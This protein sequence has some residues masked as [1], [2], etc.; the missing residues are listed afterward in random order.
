MG[1][2]REALEALGHPDGAFPEPRLLAELFVRFQAQVPLRDAPEGSPDEHLAAWLGDGA[3]LCGAARTAAFAALAAAAGFALAPASAT[4]ASGGS[5]AVL[6]AG[7]GRLLLDPSFPLPAPLPFDPPAES[8]ACGYGA[9][10][11]RDEAGGHAVALETRGAERVLY[12]VEREPDAT[13]GA[14]ARRSTAA[15]TGPSRDRRAQA[16]TLFRLLDDRLL[17]WSAGVLEVSDSW[18]R[19]RV[20]F[21]A[22]DADGLEALFGPP[23][24]AAESAAAAGVPLEPTLAVYLASGARPESL[25]AVLADPGAFACT[26]PAGWLARTREVRPDGFAWSVREGEEVLRAERMRLAPDGFVLEAEGPLALF[27]A[28]TFRLEP[29]AEGCRLRLLAT[30]RD[31]VPPRGLPEA[32]RRRLVFELANELLALD[33]VAAET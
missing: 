33:R 18:S 28:R 3:G 4:D 13:D 1:A 10:S 8:A 29:R 24:A 16:P 5:R 23:P 19:L 12:R 22:H 30:L 2:V 9:L 21:P 6:F 15:P 7:Q 26:L 32:T 25:R 27:R 31:P 14:A 11:V 20:P 17:R